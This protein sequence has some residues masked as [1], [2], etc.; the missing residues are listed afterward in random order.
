MLEAGG[1]LRSATGRPL[2]RTVD[3][4][5]LVGITVLAAVSSPALPGASI[6]LPLP[7]LESQQQGGAATLGVSTHVQ[8]TGGGGL[9]L[10]NSRNGTFVVTASN[11]KP[12]AQA[13]GSV[14]ITNTGAPSTVTLSETGITSGG[15]GTGN[16]AADLLLMVTDTTTSTVL[17]SG[18][19]NGLPATA[20]CGAT[21][22]GQC[23]SWAKGEAHTVTVSVRF[24]NS[25]NNSYQ[26]TS[27][28]A[29]FVWTATK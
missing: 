24:P 28:S 25:S 5:L 6:R 19:F 23:A 4:L 29:T 15:R 21:K 2:G 11:I 1:P 13:S 18:A 14:Q 20:L 9:S 7:M 26:A 10:T 22:H 3:L 16:L 8:P 17:F 12:G 27:A